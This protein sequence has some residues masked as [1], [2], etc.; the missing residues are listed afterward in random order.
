M[1]TLATPQQPV[2]SNANEIAAAVIR[3]LRDY[4]LNMQVK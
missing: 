3:G 2:Q 1:R 4:G